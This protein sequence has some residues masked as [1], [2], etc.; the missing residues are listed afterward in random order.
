MNW[1]HPGYL[2]ILWAIPIL[3][4]LFIIAR[5]REY[6]FLKDTVDTKL[7]PDFHTK[8]W[9]KE[10]LQFSLYLVSLAF[11]IISASGPRWGEKSR[12]IKGKGIDIM[13]SIDASKSMYCQ[14]IK[15][16]R[17]A[18]AKL[19][20]S[21]L[22]DKL[23]G[24]GRISITAFAGNSYLLC[25]LTTDFSTAKLYLSTIEPGLIPSP[26]TNLERAIEVSTNAFFASKR[27]GKVII[28]ITDGDNLQGDPISA[29]KESARKGV[30]VY[31]IVVGTPEGAPVPII[32]STGALKGYK[33]DKKGN[34]IISRANIPMLRAISQAGEGKFIILTS[35][36]YNMLYRELKR[37]KRHTIKG[38]DQIELEEKYQYFLGISIILLIMGMLINK[39]R[40]I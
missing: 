1:A 22:I 18:V 4:F 3:I 21:S 26:G 38:E 9:G 5:K 14:D 25:P 28:L 10:K 11:L 32:D 19:V 35:Q 33:K 24:I 37:L 16:D 29:A 15:P 23:G 27:Y 20:L 34:P 31:T 30:K 8:S 40:K 39:R 12:K 36:G 13:F 17:M 6:K 7:Q 2:E